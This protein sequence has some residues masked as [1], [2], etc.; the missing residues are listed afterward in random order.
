MV[1]VL[2]E[3]VC[4]IIEVKKTLDEGAMKEA[5]DNIWRAK[6][7]VA[8]EERLH[9][10]STVFCG[11]LAFESVLAPKTLYSTVYQKCYEEQFNVCNGEFWLP[12]LLISLNALAIR[13]VEKR[14]GGK[15]EWLFQWTPVIIQE[16]NFG[17]Q[18]LLVRLMDQVRMAEASQAR[19][20]RLAF[21]VNARWEDAFSL[22]IS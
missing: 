2:P 6:N 18:L 5:L 4:G 12:D 10:P 1:I 16:K 13:K 21:P 15:H 22:G 11:I 8:Y 14:S 9:D 7:F 3:A 20:G 19:V 17:L